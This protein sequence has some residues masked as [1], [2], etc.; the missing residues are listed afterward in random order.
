MRLTEA[1]V[2]AIMQVLKGYSK[3]GQVYLHGSRI[4]DKKKGGDIDLFF[5]VD[6]AEYEKLTA[7]KYKISAE[8]SLNLREQKADLLILSKSESEKHEFFNNSNKVQLS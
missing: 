8:L 2:K 6:D 7:Q 5:V 1:E 3:G 4:D